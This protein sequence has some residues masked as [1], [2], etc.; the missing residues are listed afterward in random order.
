MADENN[1]NVSA[2][3]PTNQKLNSGQFKV[4][5][6]YN[7]NIFDP[8]KLLSAVNTYNSLNYTVNKTLGMDTRWF[9]AVPQQRSKDVILKEYTLSNVEEMPKCIK[10]MLKNG[11]FP[12]G[13]YQ[14]DLGGLEY[15][16]PLEIQIDK[17]YWEEEQGFGTTPQKKDIVY[18][19]LPHKLFQVESSFL[20][21]G[22]MQQETTWVIN[23]RK[24]MPESSRKE[25][26]AL[27][28]IIDQY[29]VSEEELFGSEQQENISRLTNDKQFSPMNSTEID[30]YKTVDTSMAILASTIDIWGTFAAQSAYD[31][32][33]SDI[34]NAIRYSNTDETISITDDRS[35]MS[36]VNIK[37]NTGN[38][39]DVLDITYDANSLTPPAN[40]RIRF[41]TTKVFS[42]GDTF[43]I[44]RPGALNFYATVIDVDT[45]NYIYHCQID[46]DV[47]TYLQSIMANW[48][49][50][51]NYKMSVIDPINL[52]NGEKNSASVL[53]VDLYANQFLKI[54]YGN[55]T[56]VSAITNRLYDNTWYGITINIGNTWRQYNTYVWEKSSTRDNKLKVTHY[57]TLS[58]IP[59]EIYI[60]EYSINSSRSYMTNIRMFNCTVEEEHQKNEFLSYISMNADKAII[61][62]N[63]DLKMSIPYINK[64]R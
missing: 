58:F 34:Y 62:D 61:L 7:P 11:E 26:D 5:P 46:D 10:V 4:V 21:R 40:Y 55:Q 48:A 2:S 16:V 37:P 47:I 54:V 30:K 14:F 19:P 45:Q 49:S 32:E 25:S 63:A 59:E 36:W 12:T 8:N 20:K 41:K 60:D 15:E 38:V 56:H 3:D 1:Q 29:T 24:Y 31:M 44:N 52:I 43:V 23:L 51:R 28:E 64:P 57:D 18:M 35:V 9:R 39:Y 53:K 50:A 22:F 6:G 17:H 42:I 33:T 13:D 27:K